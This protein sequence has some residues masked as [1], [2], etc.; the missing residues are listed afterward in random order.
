VRSK[1]AAR[2][3]L[4]DLVAMGVTDQE[5]SDYALL[6]ILDITPWSRV[7]PEKLTGAQQQGKSQHFIEPAGSFPYSQE[8]AT[9]LS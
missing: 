8:P 7:L 5:V 2:L 9:C 4:F 3:F 1:C 6:S